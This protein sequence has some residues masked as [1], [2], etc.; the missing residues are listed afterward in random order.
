[1]KSSDESF[2]G[3]DEETELVSS[4]GALYVNRDSM[5]DGSTL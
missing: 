4:D 1:M 5:I 3:S 2:D